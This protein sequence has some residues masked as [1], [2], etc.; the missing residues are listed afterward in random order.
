MLVTHCTGGGQQDQLPWG[1]QALWQDSASPISFHLVSD[2]VTFCHLYTLHTCLI[3][4]SLVSLHHCHLHPIRHRQELLKWWCCTIR[5][6]A[7][8]GHFWRFSLNVSVEI[9]A[10]NYY[11]MINATQ[12]KLWI[13]SGHATQVKVLENVI[14]YKGRKALCKSMQTSLLQHTQS[15]PWAYSEHTLRECSESILGSTL[16]SSLV[17]N[18]EGTLE[19]MVESTLE[20]T[21]ESTPES[22]LQNTQESIQRAL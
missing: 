5:P 12:S 21:L 1:F 18:P 8:A 4:V 16:V 9:L 7:A 6:V 15:T 13:Y 20:N 22:I 2:I 11:N 3:I 17:S 10:P 19:S 14:M